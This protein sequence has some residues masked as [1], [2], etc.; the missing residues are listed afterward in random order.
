MRTVAVIVLLGLAITACGLL[1]HRPDTAKASE[2]AQAALDQWATA[3]GEIGPGAVIAPVGDLTGQVGDWEPN[4]GDNNKPAL[5]AGRIFTMAEL[6]GPAQE[7]EVT[8]PDGS[9]TRIPVMSA[10]A[11]IVAIADAAK[12]AQAPCPECTDLIATDAELIEVAIQTTRGPATAPVWSFTIDG[13]A[14]KVT[15]VAIANAVAVPQLPWDSSFSSVGMHLDSA[16]GSVT[17]TEVTVS[18]IGAPEPGNK[19]CGEDYTAGAVESDLAVVIIVIRGPTNVG[20]GGG[21]TAVGAVR[22]AIATLEAP[23]GN[24]AVLNVD[25]GQPVPMTLLP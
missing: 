17:G 4:V 7:G 13:T 8:W 23:L 3:V 12:A 14:V 25:S 10:Q 15:R 6:E 9:T 16:R 18:F 24:R 11:A 20:F 2:Q 22:T 5:M 21:C 1:P 19:P